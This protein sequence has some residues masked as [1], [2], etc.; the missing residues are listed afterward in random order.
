MKKL[1]ELSSKI[2]II[3]FFTGLVGFIIINIIFADFNETL[4][5]TGYTIIDFEFTWNTE[6]MD[7]LLVAWNPHLDT[8]ITF[9]WIDMIYPIFYVMLISGW[10]VAIN[11]VTDKGKSI[12]NTSFISITVAG[13]CDYIE[14]IASLMVLNY[15]NNYASFL[16]PIISIFA[17]IKFLLL[18][19]SV[20]L[21]IM[22]Y[23][24]KKMN[25]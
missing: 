24:S 3:W 20:V 13:I 18:L 10:T 17:S 7:V 23:F 2:K 25:N 8:A 9:L 4:N 16:V 1:H 12:F 15:P 14:N 22:H 11:P 5:A 6:S 21:N 19:L